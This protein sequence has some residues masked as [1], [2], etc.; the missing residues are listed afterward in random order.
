MENAVTVCQQG[1]KLEQAHRYQL[2]P[3]A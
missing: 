2:C 1:Q 3:K